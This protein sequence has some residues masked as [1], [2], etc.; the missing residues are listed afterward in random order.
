MEHFL[1]YTANSSL[2]S[3]VA[4]PVSDARKIL[5]EGSRF[6]VF[7]RVICK[8]VGKLLSEGQ[9]SQQGAIRTV[10]GLMHRNQARIF[11]L[12]NPD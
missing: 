8:A 11:G 10:E 2:L 3:S 7:D 4:G 5:S 9:I 12:E 1:L 6:E